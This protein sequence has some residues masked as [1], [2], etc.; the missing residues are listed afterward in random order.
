M[1]L[2]MPKSK[3]KSLEKIGMLNHKITTINI[4]KPAPICSNGTK[5]KIKTTSSSHKTKYKKKENIL[6]VA[7]T[8][9]TKKKISYNLCIS[10]FK[11]RD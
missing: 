3:V 2:N 5:N 4:P 10:Y 7:K 8:G 9:M 11:G 6:I 1:D